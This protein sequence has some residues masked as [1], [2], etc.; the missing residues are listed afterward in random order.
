MEWNEMEGFWLVGHGGRH[1]VLGIKT[2][3]LLQLSF[4]C[5]KDRAYAQQ[6]AAPQLAAPHSNPSPC[7]ADSSSAVISYRL[8]PVA[9]VP[10]C[11]PA[12]PAADRDIAAGEEVLH[13]YGDLADA[14]LLQTYGF[15][16]EWG[17]GE[18]NP[19]NVAFIPAD[20]VVEGCT[21]IGK[22]AGVYGSNAGAKGGSR[23]RKGRGEEG[24]AAGSKAGSKAGGKEGGKEGGVEA[25]VARRRQLAEL[26]GL[27][28]PN[29]VVVLAE[30]PLTDELLSVAQVRRCLGVLSCVSWFA[31]EWNAAVP[32]QQSGASSGGEQALFRCS[33]P[34]SGSCT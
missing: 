5:G 2:P 21:A 22:A 4:S 3:L 32:D 17:P 12:L 30:A 1:A 20:L 7:P 19:H 9:K 8:Q 25:V 14:Q 18:A 27:L 11:L 24:E 23:K 26:L 10:V 15:V 16:E 29:V 31:G 34:P 33:C 28:P 6:L 13:T